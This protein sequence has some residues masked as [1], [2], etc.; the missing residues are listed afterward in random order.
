M[1]GSEVGDAG[2]GLAHRLAEPAH[3]RGILDALGL[4]STP[5]L[6]STAQGRT[7]RTPSITLQDVNPPDKT[8]GRGTLGGMSDQSNAFPPPP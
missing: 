5:E 6:T 1:G 3:Q 7:L 8:T 4:T 2:I